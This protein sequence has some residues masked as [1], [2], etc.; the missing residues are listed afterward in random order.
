MSLTRR[1][2]ACKSF[3]CQERNQHLRRSPVVAGPAPAVAIQ[4]EQ[5]IVVGETCEVLLKREKAEAEAVKADEEE[6][7]RVTKVHKA[8]NL[9]NDRLA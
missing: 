8:G 7:A 9:T 4:T 5:G 3:Q 6:Q 2:K 1:I